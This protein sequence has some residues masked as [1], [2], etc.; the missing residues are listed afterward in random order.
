L[1]TR[2]KDL[3][4]EIS[5]WQQDRN[6]YLQVE[7]NLKQMRSQIKSI[8]I[9]Q[10]DD[11]VLEQLERHLKETQED[12]VKMK[13]KIQIQLELGKLQELYQQHGQSQERCQQLNQ[14]LASLQ[15]IKSTLITAEYIILDTFLN[16]VNEQLAEVLEP[17][18]KEPIS[19]TLRS[20]K[21]LKTDQRIKPQVNYEI[22]IG[23]T[24]CVSI[25]EI[26]G[27]ERSRI[28]LALAIV[29]S[30]FNRAPFLLLD[31]SLSTLD[32]EIKERTM[33]TIR[34][35]LQNKLVIAVNHDTTT[36][37]YDSVINLAK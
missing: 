16:H 4:G 31:E 11:T 12:Y 7:S 22:N 26:S 20:L 33:D 37:V 9:E 24:E 36:G 35:Y 27:G 2:K 30:T 18:F 29:F 28:S 1:N 32:S 14:R 25:N 34:K 8:T 23:G 17:L 6:E 15:K 21:Q 10:V 5:K 13:Q 3:Q 19:V